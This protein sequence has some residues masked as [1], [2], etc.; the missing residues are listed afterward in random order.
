[1]VREEDFRSRIGEDGHY[2]DLIDFSAIE[3]FNVPPT[4]TILRFKVV[5]PIRW[6]CC[7]F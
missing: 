2:F 4:M 3:G 6:V 7:F 5:N 1:V